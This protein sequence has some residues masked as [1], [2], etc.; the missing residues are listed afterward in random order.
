MPPVVAFNHAETK[1]VSQMRFLPPPP[2]E[3]QLAETASS[4][5]SVGRFGL[6]K[7][8]D[9]MKQC[10]W[11]GFKLFEGIRLS[12]LQQLSKFHNLFIRQRQIDPAF[13]HKS[14]CRWAGLRTS[15]GILQSTRLLRL[16]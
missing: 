16:R 8:S 13:Q 10:V 11:N 12:V 9:L 4:A 2:V 6:R 15:I 1:S 14:A 3:K 5:E 7:F